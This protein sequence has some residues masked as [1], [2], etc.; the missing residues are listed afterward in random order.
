M[1]RKYVTPSLHSL[2]NPNFKI[3]YFQD[4]IEKILPDLL[5]KHVFGPQVQNIP[6][7]IVSLGRAESILC[8][9]SRGVPGSLA[10]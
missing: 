7:I 1:Y 4:F 8:N 2:T 3:K 5:S 6:Q 9:I 10:R